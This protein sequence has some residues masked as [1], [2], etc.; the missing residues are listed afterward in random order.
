MWTESLSTKI[1]GAPQPYLLEFHD[2]DRT[3]SG[4]VSEISEEGRVKESGET[5]YS[6]FSNSS[7]S[8]R[9]HWQHRR[10]SYAITPRTPGV[11]AQNKR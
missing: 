6:H 8:A 3:F 10:S 4:S 7:A 11:D 9:R 2:N 1:T 5:T